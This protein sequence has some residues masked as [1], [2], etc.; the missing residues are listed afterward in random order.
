MNNRLTKANES[1]QY[2]KFR[3]AARE[4][5]CDESEERFDAAL[6]KIVAFKPDEKREARAVAHASDCAVHNG[7]AFDAGP[8][9]CGAV[10]G[11]L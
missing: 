10:K 1:Q 9:D 6:G 5:G 11:G 7:P 8:C 4:L 3:E 2:D